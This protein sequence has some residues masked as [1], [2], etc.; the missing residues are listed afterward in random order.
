MR[1]VAVKVAYEGAGF[2]GSQIQPEKRTIE[3]EI[4]SNLIRIGN[5]KGEEWFDLKCSSR[6]D[7]GVNALGNVFVFNTEFDDNFQLLTALNSVSDGI[8]Y[9]GICTVDEEFNP[10]HANYREY[11]YVIPGKGID[12]EL[13]KKCATLFEGEH[14]FKRFCKA[15]GKDTTI[16]LEHVSVAKEN[17]NIVITFKSR[18]FLWNLIRRLSAA[19]ISVGKGRSSLEEVSRALNGEEMTFGLARADALTLVDVYYEILDFEMINT[20]PLEAKAYNESFTSSLR[21]TFFDSICEN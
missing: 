9:R 11:R 18:F 2:S 21:K 16:V 3:G 5:D 15:D 7:A 8:F 1:R 13:V 14:D 17:D 10:R 4:L 6:T 12:F 19:I 20:S